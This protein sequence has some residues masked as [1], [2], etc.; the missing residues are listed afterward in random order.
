MLCWAGWNRAGCSSVARSREGH[1]A[2]FAAFAVGD[3]DAARVEVDLVEADRDE[4]GDAHAGV[5]QGF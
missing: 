3:A 5:E 4:F 2:V 1:V